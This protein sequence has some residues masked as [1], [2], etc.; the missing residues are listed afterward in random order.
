MFREER[1]MNLLIWFGAVCPIVVLFFAM[2]VLHMKT[3]R[4]AMLGI[5][6]AAVAALLVGQ[7]SPMIVGTDLVKGAF[8]ALN[9]L[10]VI[11]PAIFLYE[12]LRHAKVF[13][14]I[15]QMIQ[16]LTK[17]E[18]VV[19]MLICW[20][21]S[22]YLQSITGFGV[23]VAVCA[24][25]LMAVGVRPFWAVI[26]TLL[27]HAWAN[28]YGTCALAWDALLIQS[29]TTEVFGTKVIAGFFL[30]GINFVGACLV[31]YIY[32]KKKAL[33]HMLPFI[34]IISTIH[35][36]GQMLVSFLNGTIAAFI[37]T[38]LAILVAW[39]LL[40]A[41]FYTKSWKVDSKIVDSAALSCEE[42]ETTGK[43]SD[44]VMPFV[45]LAVISV[46]ILLVKPIH[47]FL[48]QVTIQLSFPELVTGR[49]FVVPATNTYGAIHI[50]THAGFV[51]LLTVLATYGIYRKKKMLS[52]GQFPS[53]RAAAVK[54]L[55]PT[56]LGILMLV[57]MAQVLK[58]S[59]LMEI[60]A[61]GVTQVTGNF[62]SAAVPC[63]GVLG[64][65]VTSSNTS[66][67]ILLG[68]FQKVAADMIG[69][70]EAAVLAAQTAGGAIGTVVGPSTILLGTTT[71]G[72]KGKEGD[73]LKFMLPIVLIQGIV[74]GVIAWVLSSSV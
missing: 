12:T 73:V 68:N 43:S 60:V 4:A 54:K 17:D 59:G 61:Q 44:A 40:K 1:K 14:T 71:A 39:G 63:V 52:A 23:P 29:E 2:S 15:R 46:V 66:S 42:E 28:T 45:I 11:W 55:I 22:S 64:A 9:I 72:C 3:E 8:S 67:N 74:F 41:G 34:A 10:I 13:G 18:L 70:N 26:I 57:M 56:S 36:L 47:S 49:G 6:F 32:G 65:F 51:L 16:N 19:I 69:A 53:V 27:G 38:T 7:S 30:W 48:N 5:A 24:P 50:F 37:P 58:G 62:Y 20:L 33:L 35:G 21:F 25:L 31:S